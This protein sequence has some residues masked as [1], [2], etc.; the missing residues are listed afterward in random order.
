MLGF[1]LNQIDRRL[2]IFVGDI[3]G[4]ADL[5]AG[6]AP[7][8]DLAVLRD[9]EMTGERGAVL[10]LLQRADMGRQRLRQHRHDAVRERNAVAAL[11]RL[12]VEGG[13]G[14]DVEAD[15]RSEE[16]TSELQSLTRHSYA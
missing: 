2:R 11:S 15:I 1:L 6:E 12:L 7:V 10:A 16:H 3:G 5:G 9:L 13:A 14:A 8:L 4:Y